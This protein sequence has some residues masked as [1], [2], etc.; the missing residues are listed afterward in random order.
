MGFISTRKDIKA[1]SISVYQ[2]NFGLIREKRSINLSGEEEKIY[3]LDVSELIEVNSIIVENIDAYEI[4]Y[5]Y[6]V[7][8]PRDVLEK[9]I[10]KEVTLFDPDSGK[11]V[12]GILLATQGGY[13]I[14]DAKTNEVYVSPKGEIILPCLPKGFVLKPT[15]AFKICPTNSREFTVSYLTKGLVWMAN[16]TIELYS[17]YL[18]LNCYAQ[19]DNTTGIDLKNT[20]V[21]LVS[22]DIKRF[23][24]TPPVVPYNEA[25]FMVKSSSAVAGVSPTALGDYYIY[26]YPFTTDLNNKTSKQIRLFWSKNVRYTKYYTNPFNG[27][28]LSTVIEFKNSRNNNLGEPLP[29]GIAKV[30]DTLK[31]RN[32][33][34]FIG[35]GEIDYTPED[36]LVKL[37]LGRPFNIVFDKVQTDYR[38]LEGIEEYEYEITIK[39]TG[40]EEALLKVTHFIPGDWKM[41]SSTDRFI[42]K[43]ANTIE[44]IVSVSPKS[45]KKIIFRYAVV[46]IE[47]NREQE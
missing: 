39:N 36:E 17:Q 28:E 21:S 37:E 47:P 45:E 20:E 41:I 1:L 31:D 25:S 42:K 40:N 14:E 18:S 7:I 2:N 6:D 11:K 15:I 10:G 12:H 5:D 8:N 30:Y 4:N 16:Y 46:V 26:N 13:I 3:Y 33:L 32:N 22:G 29:N 35:E 23:K 43:D 9:F 19:I 44:F 38:R 24:E 27:N 34:E